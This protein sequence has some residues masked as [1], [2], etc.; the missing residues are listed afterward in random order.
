VPNY[1]PYTYRCCTCTKEVTAR[2]FACLACK[3]PSFGL[4]KRQAAGSALAT[5]C[6]HC[7][8]QTNNS[9]LPTECSAC[10]GEHCD[11]WDEQ[12]QTW[13]GL[14]LSFKEPIPKGAVWLTGDFDGDYEGTPKDRQTGAADD[15]RNLSSYSIKFTSGYLSNARVIDAPPTSVALSEKRP[16]RFAAV[17]PVDI[18]PAAAPDSQPAGEYRVALADFRLHNWQQIAAAASP[19]LGSSR[20]LGR[21]KGQGYGLLIKEEQEFYKN[22]PVQPSAATSTAAAVASEEPGSGAAASDTT[23]ATHQTVTTAT[24]NTQP[25]DPTD[26][27]PEPSSYEPC[28]MCSTLAEFCL[29]VLAWIQCDFWTAF[30]LILLTNIACWLDA[31][32]AGAN[33]KFE[34]RMTK[35]FVA[36]SLLAGSMLG[37]YIEFLPWLQTDCR[38]F[39]QISLV[40]A[41]V[42]VLLGITLRSCFVKFLLLI[43]LLLALSK[44]CTVGNASCQTSSLLNPITQ[45]SSSFMQNVSSFLNLDAP[46][47]GVGGSSLTMDSNIISDAS[48]SG[49]G[50]SGRRISIDEAARNPELLQNCRN[51][52]Y[53]PFEYADATIQPDIAAKFNRLGAVLK[54]YEGANIVIIGYTDTTGDETLEGFKQNIELSQLRA[55]TVAQWLFSNAYVRPDKADIRWAGSSIPITTNPSALRLNRRVEIN[56]RCAGS[57]QGGG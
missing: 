54:R 46:S 45:A 32:A 56:I 11:W 20:L 29:F 53:I 18:E 23:A 16:F 10:G 33:I 49:S 36:L 28:F 6:G 31:W 2:Q 12:Q 9:S 37:L 30:G 25:T 51:R 24:G 35:A 57:T 50:E 40:V 52:V 34:S 14:D 44:W 3:T 42:A 39:A 8:T 27:T 41:A 15:P 1:S 22:P 19:S 4:F 43:I 13:A 47:Q 55:N 26:S 21:V 17:H 7:S 5:V 38:T 48:M